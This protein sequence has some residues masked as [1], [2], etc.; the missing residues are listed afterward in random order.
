ML[1]HA[2]RPIAALLLVFVLCGGSS[3]AQD[4]RQPLTVKDKQLII[5]DL[6]KLL[7]QFYVYPDN[8][9]KMG[10]VIQKKL[11]SG[12][13]DSISDP[14]Q[15]AAGLMDDIRTVNKDKHLNFYYGPQEAAEALHR[16]SQDAAEVSQARERFL[17]AQQRDNFGFRKVERLPGNV[18]YL[19][20]R[21][22]VPAATA[23]ETA[24]AALTFL[25]YCDAIIIDLRQNGGGDPS[26][27][28]LISSY[29]FPEPT[30]LNDIYTRAED[31][32]ENFWTL[33]YVPGRKPLEADLY[34]LTS[35]ETFSGAEE[36]SYNMKN[37][38]R[39]TLIGETTG[40]GAHPTDEKVIQSK[41]I[42]AV[43]SARA[44]N[45]ITKTNWEGT[46]VTPDIAVP[47][48]QAFDKAYAMALE[49]LASKATNPDQKREAEWVLSLQK[50]KT[51]PVHIDQATQQM[52]AGVYGERK[53]T[54]ENGQLYYQ[55]TGPKYR[56]IPLNNTTFIP[57]GLDDFRLQFT[58]IDGKATEV[59]GMMI[60]GMRDVSKRTN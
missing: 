48:P 41:F 39:A 3:F 52:Y 60:D 31:K 23:G 45:P 30:H 9:Q 1:K 4:A 35:K 11:S 51:N 38:K 47:A 58:V 28:Q 22:F 34:I 56:L 20:F 42:L 50:A 40:G 32:M 19:D 49:K 26:Q 18:G 25:A 59:V 6:V 16:Q 7:N 37:L 44:I 54:L 57:E 15:F 43:P 46:G 33:P 13:Y 21:M 8:A 55:R 10:E 53:V 27:I 14:V 29:F 2:T 17:A 24:I 36:F 5:E 12:G